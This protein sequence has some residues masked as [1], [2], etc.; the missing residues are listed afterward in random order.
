METEDKKV[1]LE[2]QFSSLSELGFQK[3]KNSID[4][5]F[6]SPTT[7]WKSIWLTYLIQF[8]CGIQLSVYFTSM[9]PYLSGVS[10]L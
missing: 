3:G 1:P 7:P 9:W 4:D 10:G 5:K 6:N 2:L 8:L